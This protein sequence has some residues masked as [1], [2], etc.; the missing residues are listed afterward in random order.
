MVTFRNLNYVQV[1]KTLF[2]CQ[3][4]RHE[5][6]T[7][8]DGQKEYVQIDQNDLFPFLLVNV[9]S[10]VS[11]IKVT[12]SLFFFVSLHI[13]D[14]SFSKVDGHGKFQRVSGTNV[15]GGTYWGLGRLM[16]KCKR[17]SFCLFMDVIHSIE[18]FEYS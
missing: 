12:S 17:C 2:C 7:H 16:T 8:M 3:A 13:V 14:C 1:K 4:I 15:G 10:G 11:I 9:G 5:A 18:K 6:F